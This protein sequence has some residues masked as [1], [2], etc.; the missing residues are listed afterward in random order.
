[1]IITNVNGCVD[2][3]TSTV[4]VEVTYAAEG[5]TSEQR[6]TFIVKIDEMNEIDVRVFNLPN[7]PLSTKNQQIAN[8]AKVRDF[9]IKSLCYT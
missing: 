6:Q 7:Q 4:T 3:C 5:T 8:D 2:K 1:M 9:A